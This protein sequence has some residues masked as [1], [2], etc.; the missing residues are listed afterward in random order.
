MGKTAKIVVLPGDGIGKEV[1][2]ESI[3]VLKAT[4]ADCEFLEYS[5]GGEEYLNNDT[6]L[7][8][9]AIDAINSSDA[10][11]FGAVGHELVPDQISR[12]PL[13]YLR[14]EK[15][16]FANVRP[17]KNYRIDRNKGAPNS[18]IDIVIIRD[19]SEGFSLKHDGQLDDNMDSDRR[20]ITNYGAKRIIKYAF[21][22]AGVNN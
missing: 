14:M 12:Q 10:V 22:Y 20:I 3:K 5:V 18:D 17:L 4:G 7:P 19:N 11:L 16:T 15:S 1:I 13:I 8:L 2:A 6:S 9:K 21:D